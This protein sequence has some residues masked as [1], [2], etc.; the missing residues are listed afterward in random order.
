[1]TLVIRNPTQQMLDILVDEAKLVQSVAMI[2]FCAVPLGAQTLEPD[3]LG[4]NPTGWYIGH[5]LK[6]LHPTVSSSV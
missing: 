5:V 2:Q 4:L 1:M 3:C 6:C